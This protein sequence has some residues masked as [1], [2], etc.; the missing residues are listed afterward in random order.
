MFHHNMAKLLFL[1]KR[2][3]PNVQTATAFLCTRVKAT[4]V[5]DY[6]K[7]GRVM[8]Y[9]WAT[10][11]MVLTLECNNMSIIKWWV[12][13]SFAVHLDMKSHT[14]TVITLGQGAMY[15]TSM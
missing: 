12:D 10:D 4:D 7:L 11:D 8:C 14:G 9:L 5:D 3:H 1:C 13:T 6:K 2:A 15:S